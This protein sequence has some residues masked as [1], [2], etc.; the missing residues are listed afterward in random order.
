MLCH[1]FFKFS[2]FLNESLCLCIPPTH[3]TLLANFTTART[4]SLQRLYSRLW[5]TDL[6]M[7]ISTVWTWLNPPGEEALYGGNTLTMTAYLF[8]TTYSTLW[9]TQSCILQ[10]RATSSL[11]VCGIRSRLDHIVSHVQAPMFCWQT[12]APYGLLLKIMSHFNTTAN[13]VVMCFIM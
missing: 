5:T 6:R 12:E 4:K 10:H 13:K 2:D 3:I 1:L 7:N 9:N 11:E 8:P